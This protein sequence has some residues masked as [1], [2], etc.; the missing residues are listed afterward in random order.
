[1]HLFS[2]LILEYKIV[3]YICP[4]LKFL[5]SQE[6]P[7]FQLYVKEF[8]VH[9]DIQ[10]IATEIQFASEVLLSK[11]HEK[12]KPITVLFETDMPD[13]HVN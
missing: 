1:M 12:H 2:Q 5:I 4:F 3:G 13:F 11:L 7:C 9:N 8:L 10:D 6:D